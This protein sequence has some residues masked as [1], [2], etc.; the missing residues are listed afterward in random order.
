MAIVTIDFDGTLYQ[1][2]SFKAMFHIGQ[3][4]FSSKQWVIVA[5][6]LLKALASGA[7][8]GKTKFRH[9][10]FKA[11][12]KTFKGKTT[13]ELNDFFQELV[14]FS[15]EDIH[16]SLV[17]QIRDHQRKG[18]TVIVLSGALE[19]FLKAFTKEL[20]L[21][22]HIL[23]TELLFNEKGLCTGEIGRIINGDAKVEKLN[24]WIEQQHL[25]EAS[26]KEIWAYADSESDIPLLNF[27]TH[28]IVVNPKEDMIKIA[29]QNKWA[30]FA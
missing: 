17:Q 24:E 28:P 14:N 12:A 6:G 27:V 3:K 26:T 29:Q 19:P 10:F 8:Q 1:G 4:K 23:S 15:K 9:D 25:T 18:D 2:N 16:E 22:V 30:I 21:D 13:A 7:V 11:F 5:A 20:L